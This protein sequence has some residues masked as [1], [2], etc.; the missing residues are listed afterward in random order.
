[1][2]ENLSI[3][4]AVQGARKRLINGDV[5]RGAGRL[6]TVVG[7]A[8][9][10]LCIGDN[11]IRLPSGLRLAAGIS[12]LGAAAA[13]ISARILA[14]IRRRRRH[15]AVA[16]ELEKQFGVDQNKLINA[17]QF[18][19][20]GLTP[21]EASFG[22]AVRVEASQAIARIPPRSLWDLRL[23][24]REL[25][26]LAGCLLLVTAYGTGAPRYAANA[27]L[28]VLFPLADIPPAGTVILTLQP[29]TN[30]E[31]GEGDSLSVMVTARTPD[32]A[33]LSD[34]PTI[35]HRDMADT[36]PTSEGKG[37]A[38]MLAQPGN[39]LGW[40]YGFTKVER[41][42]AFRVFAAD[43]Y[44]RAIRVTVRPNPRLTASSFTVEPPAYTALPAET[45]PGP[46]SALNALPGSRIT[47][48]VSVHPQADRL[49]WTDAEGARPFK[50][51]K[52]EF[53]L[54]LALTNSGPYSITA[55]R[56]GT[57]PEWVVAQG[58]LA[59][60]EDR[61][62]EVDFD[63]PDRNRYVNPGGAVEL[64]VKA[65]DDYGVRLL[66]VTARP[67][68]EKN[69]ATGML[70]R[71]WAFMGPPGPKKPAAETLRLTLD[72]LLFPPG[73][74]WALE[75]EAA[76]FSP[77]DRRG[78]SAPLLLRVR[79]AKDV[80][81][82]DDS[83][84]SKALA[85]LRETIA[86]QE[87]ANTATENLRLNLQDALLNKPVIDLSTGLRDLQALAQYSGRK[88]LDAFKAAKD[89]GIPT[90]VR[91]DPLVNGEMETVRDSLHRLPDTAAD[92]L[93]KRLVVIRER[94]DYI[95]AE[96]I[97]LLGRAADRSAEKPKMETKKEGAEAP[98][99]EARQ[100]VRELREDLKDFIEAQKK[101]LER[102]KTLLDKAPQDLSD[103]E[104]KILGELAREEAK[105][106]SY[107]E[108][109]LTDFSKLPLQDFADGS[110][111]EEFNETFMEMKKAAKSLYEKKIELA[112]PQEQSGLENA[113]ELVQNL[114]KWLS[115]KPDNLKWLMEEPE[116]PADIAMAELPAELEDIVGELLDKEEEMTE[117][118]EDV[119]SSWMDSPDKGAGWDAL[120]GP[121]SSMAAKGVT[122]NMLPNQME[123]GGRSGEG[124]S[125]RS[126]GQM[127]EETA[128]GKGGRETP[129]RLSPSPFETG[130]VEDSSKESPGG[131]TGGGKLS[132]FAGEGLRGPVPPPLQQKMERLAGQQAQIRQAAEA[133]ALR[134]R[135]WN[136]P[137]ADLETAV[138]HMREVETSAAKGYGPGVRQAFT[139]A[140]GT[141]EAA[142]KSVAGPAALRREQTALPEK[143][144]QEITSGLQDGV[145]AGYEE[146]AGAY[147]REL[148][149]P[150]R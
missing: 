59:L 108:E 132:G 37:D 18:E 52:A 41:S 146:M 58:S 109:K 46:P 122:G 71:A 35:K 32:G 25:L 42:F 14:P 98:L 96:L 80:T 15:E 28:R 104:E 86:A 114:E 128:Q 68:E 44:S 9:L 26:I 30:I 6:L 50:T 81:A 60:E 47:A 24:R 62:P 5:T 79:S 83:P 110:L 12:L 45:R 97:T 90:A 1:M 20:G 127:V 121:I 118:V 84:L 149:E 92:A 51:T 34:P 133:L 54:A 136:V 139:E 87:H 150:G 138:Q 101:I 55:P 21:E 115:D 120:D 94:Q 72:P 4:S 123:I 141:L 145:P 10:L 135:A 48:T 61:P 75:A 112:V 64:P 134:L 88:A 33:P 131:A 23:L 16:V 67:F 49:T 11:L 111:A 140:L 74:I 103:E 99:Q 148:A 38:P 76:D 77:H 29:E 40:T 39:P 125:G 53:T 13:L 8:L 66:Q 107:F 2:K 57:G 144:R 143:Q 73:T 31:L 91:L 3:H 27:L 93:E 36:I 105:W 116:T 85:L 129:T 147:F 100:E 130:S 43:T 7:S 142:R 113:E 78:K 89:D 22:E 19:T 82:A 124:R 117:D 95:L 56:A 126:S 69:G 106:A 102:S 137:G 17:W 63:T 119:T 70:L 65:E